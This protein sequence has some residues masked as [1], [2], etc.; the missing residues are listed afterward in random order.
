MERKPVHF[1]RASEPP[2]AGRG[3]GGEGRGGEGREEEGEG[4]RK[5]RREGREGEGRGEES[6]RYSLRCVKAWEF[7]PRSCKLLNCSQ[8]PKAYCFAYETW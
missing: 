3:G 8:M 2:P 4:K 1:R 7:W 5:G 6:G